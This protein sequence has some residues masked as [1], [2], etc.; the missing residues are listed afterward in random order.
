MVAVAGLLLQTRCESK[1]SKEEM[2]TTL[3]NDYMFKTLF[4]YE[5]YMPIDMQIDSTIHSPCNDT[6]I[7]RYAMIK[8][9]AMKLSD[10]CRDKA[11]Q[12]MEI[13]RVLGDYGTR[14]HPNPQKEFSYYMD[15]GV[16][17]LEKS[18]AYNDSIR[19]GSRLI[20]PDFVGWTVTHKYY[21]KDTDTITRAFYVDKD[22]TKISNVVNID[23]EDYIKCQKIIKEVLDMK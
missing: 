16:S 9:E 19:L 13:F 12:A 11:D 17:C 23:D 5:S 22:F 15:K 6:T 20:K 1:P 18:V 14:N 4:Y 2:A 8:I 7:M 21:S 10:E 3:I